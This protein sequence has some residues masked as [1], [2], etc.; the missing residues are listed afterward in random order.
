[1]TAA[2]LFLATASVMDV[3][4]SAESPV[5]PMIRLTPAAAATG[6][7]A[8]VAGATV[9]SIRTSVPELFSTAARSLGS[10]TGT[11]IAPTPAT[12]PMS[13]P[14]LTRSK[15]AEIVIPSVASTRRTIRVP[16]LPQ[17]PTRATLVSVTALPPRSLNHVGFPW[18]L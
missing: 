12:S 17:A 13:F 1:M 6:A 8:A 15:A 7:L 16:I 11:P 4:C 3:L 18:P 14:T 10:E 5:V 9:K 2:T